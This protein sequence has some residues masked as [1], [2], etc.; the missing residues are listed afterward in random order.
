MSDEQKESSV[1]FSLKELINLEEDR[2]NQE[3]VARQQEETR[4]RREREEQERR[5][6]EEEE[7]RRAAEVERVRQEE[8]RQREEQARL[9]AIRA[10]EIERQRIEA[11]QRAH[12]E[13]QQQQL[14]HAQQLEQIKQDQGKKKLRLIAGGA[15][16]LF[17]IASV[18][19][20][21]VV[22]NLQDK[23]KE[24][25]VAR[26]EAQKRAE[27][28]QARQ[29][30]EYQKALADITALQE[31]LKKTTNEVDRQKLEKQIK[32]MNQRVPQQGQG[33]RR[34]PTAPTA[35][36]AGHDCPPGSMD[37]LCR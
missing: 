8:Q 15:G 13:S 24:D 14:A 31:Q 34:N 27:T 25:E 4:K 16:L 23:A 1:L 20:V 5:A 35:P 29:R 21:T 22:V 19:G 28:E 32:E 10:A 30:A 18:I 37:P 9:E 7:A 26:V 17:V 2:V 12:L 6:R 11:Q 33:S 36:A 3:K